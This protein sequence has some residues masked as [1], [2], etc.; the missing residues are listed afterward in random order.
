MNDNVPSM[1]KENL[2]SMAAE[3]A[4]LG[5]TVDELREL[6][7]VRK[8]IIEAYEAGKGTPTKSK[9]NKLAFIFGWEAWQ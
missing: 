1:V 3:R 5:I 6:S 7:G 9:Y 2:C 4:R 8:E